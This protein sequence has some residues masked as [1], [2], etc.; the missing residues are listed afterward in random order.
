ALPETPA[1]RQQAVDIRLELRPV[2]YELGEV[3][4][5]LE[6]VR[7]AEVLVEEL[8]DDYRRGRVG[9]FATHSHVMLGQLDEARAVAARTLAI[10]H[11]LDDLEVKVLTTTFLGQALHYRG[12]YEEQVALIRE[13]LLAMP[14]D[15]V[16][17]NFGVGVPVSIFDRVQMTMTLCQLGRFA[18]A[19][20]HEAALIRLAEPT[21]HA[22]S[23]G[24]AHLAGS[25]L[26]LI[27]GDWAEA[28]SRAEYAVAVLRAGTVVAQLSTAI[29]SS[30]WAL[31]GLG[32]AREALERLQEGEQLLERQQPM[33]MGLRGWA[34]HNLGRAALRLGQ[35]DQARS[36]AARAATASPRP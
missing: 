28:R 20:G 19:A 1:T 5:V 15:W 4:A 14:P 26:R 21:D 10:A 29:A 17:R 25:M 8:N 35:L 31:A 16:Y 6:R 9:A 11:K 7:E 36:L 2:L 30:A 13:N 3:R 33:T 18:E 22:Y 32:E 23:I 27:E 12:E 34:Y 24:L